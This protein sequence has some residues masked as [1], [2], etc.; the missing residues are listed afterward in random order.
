[1]IKL[2]KNINKCKDSGVLPKTVMMKQKNNNQL[3][4]HK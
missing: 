3:P 1:M 2:T 4:T